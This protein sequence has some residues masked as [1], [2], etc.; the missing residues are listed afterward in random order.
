MKN[1]IK[2]PRLTDAEITAIIRQQMPK[3]SHRNYADAALR[4][5]CQ[6]LAIP[7]L[8]PGKYRNPFSILYEFEQWF[9]FA[10]RTIADKQPS[11]SVIQT[12][13]EGDKR[14]PADFLDNRYSSA[15]YG[16]EFRVS[17]DY[18]VAILDRR[19]ILNNASA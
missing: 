10:R 15:R 12:M 17:C 6:R 19:A 13:L 16:L 1:K 3:T 9:E 14:N 2:P 7:E 8:M 11:R 18:G 5:T 4:E